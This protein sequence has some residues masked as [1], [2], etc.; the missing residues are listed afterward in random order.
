MRRK[1][2]CLA[3]LIVGSAL[4]S[5]IGLQAQTATQSKE[6]A[7]TIDDLPLN[8]P[9]FL[10]G[11]VLKEPFAVADGHLAIPSGPGLGVEVDEGRLH[12]LAADHCRAIGG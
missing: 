5:S 2:L 4:A 8:G 7:V 12:E 1:L 3:I 10:S 6:V 9:Q 11:S